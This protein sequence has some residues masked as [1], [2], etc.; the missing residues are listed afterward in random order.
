LRRVV[1]VVLAVPACY[2]AYQLGVI[3]SAA[4]GRT[5]D[6]TKADA[7]RHK[8][9]GLEVAASDLDIG[10]VWE[11]PNFVRPVTITNRADRPVEVVDLRGGC[12]CTAVE[13]R[14]FALGPGESQRVQVRIDLT[15]RYPHQ[16]GVERREISLGLFPHLK[17]RGATAAGWTITGGVKSRVSL[18]GRGIE[19][20]DTCGQGGPPVTRKMRAT[21][22]VP[23][24]GLDAS[25][26]AEMATVGVRRVGESG[27]YHVTVTPNPSLPLGP[28]T[29]EV[30]L[31]ATLPDGSKFACSS[32]RVG[33]EM[34]SPVRVVPDPVLF[35]EHAVG[36]TAEAFVSVRFPAAS[37]SVDRVETELSETSVTPADP[38]DGRPA[39][40]ITQPVTKAGDRNCVVRFV[41]RKPDGKLETVPATLRWHGESARREKP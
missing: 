37:W 41:V 19:F 26:P 6:A 1:F 33:G 36:A 38:I 3:V 30:A 7:A 21:A 20:G 15:H 29:F 5:G 2:L 32:F 9:N 10:E 34:R 13:P 23:L 24:A 39:Y 14:S 8:I 27:Q 4:G 35:G 25:C 40:R 11:E 17:E 28:F 12:E 22:H 31:T 16:F 18:E